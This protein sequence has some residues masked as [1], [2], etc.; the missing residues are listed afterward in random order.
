MGQFNDLADLIENCR[1]MLSEQLGNLS[2]GKMTELLQWQESCIETRALLRQSFEL[3]NEY[4]ASQSELAWLKD[5]L[6]A[7]VELNNQVFDAAAK[8]RQIVAER[9]SRMRKGKS[10]LGGYSLRQGMSKPRFVSSTG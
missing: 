7:L 5:N 2:T 6:A 8:Q 3:V 9:L 4:G 1:V 10:A